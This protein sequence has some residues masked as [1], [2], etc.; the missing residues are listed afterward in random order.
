PDLESRLRKFQSE[1][2]SHIESLLRTAVRVLGRSQDA[3][4]V[5]QE[6]YLRAWRYFDSFETGSN[7]RA[8]LF[9]IMFNVIGV[10]RKKDSRVAT[11]PLEEHEEAGTGSSNV[12]FLDPLKRIEGREV[13]DAT[14]RLSEEHRSVLWLV[15]VEE[16]TYKEV[17]EVLEVPIGTVM[18]RL[19]RARRELRKRLTT[20]RAGGA[21]A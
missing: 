8:W 4:D 2:I 16:L 6:T 3:E 18:S 1:A 7:C 11:A 17:A 12:V 14:T 9:R 20:G 15:V 5:V 10:K 19:H 13:L 21:G